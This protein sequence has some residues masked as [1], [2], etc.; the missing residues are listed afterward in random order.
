MRKTLQ[1]LAAC[2]VTAGVLAGCSDSPAPRTEAKREGLA[3]D[4][5]AAI[6]RMTAADPS[7]RDFLDRAYG[8]AVFPSIGK[9]GFVVG[10][11]YG[12]GEV[13][14]EGRQ[15]GYAD[16]TAISAGL[17]AGGQ[18]IAELVVF[19]TES[20]FNNFTRG[21][22]SLGANASVVALK[23]GAA[24]GAQ[25]RDGVVTFVD[26][27][28]GL[29]ADL[30]LEGQ[31]F[32]FRADSSGGN[33]EPASY[34]RG[35]DPATRDRQEQLRNEQDRERRDLQ[36]QHQQERQ[37]LQQDQRDQ[38]QNARQ[39]L[40]LRKRDEQEAQQEAQKAQQDAQEAQR[41]AGQSQI[42][43]ERAADEA[44]QDAVKAQRDA[45]EAQPTPEPAPQDATDGPAIRGEI[46][47]GPDAA[48]KDDAQPRG[49]SGQAG[50]S[51]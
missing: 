37:Q 14:R 25:F 42:E 15:V 40:E 36:Q 12:R 3:A 13:Y 44:Q 5:E 33:A 43:A 51:E 8:Y 19:G 24:A 39:E 21:E 4:S 16:V 22:Y 32:R 41:E 45:Q 29:M 49:T 30:S 38:Q 11:S 2:V 34:Q 35:S 48:E 26:S 10:G 18:T 7:L 47:V 27:R 6:R 1:V 9:G 46:E 23:A 17:L 28:G 31:R 50:Q 20:A